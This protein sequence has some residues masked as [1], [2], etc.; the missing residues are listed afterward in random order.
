MTDSKMPAFTDFRLPDP[1]KLAQNLG[2]LA[3]RAA[4]LSRKLAERPDVQQ[5]EAEVQILPMEQV[6]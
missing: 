4:L 1:V 2:V 6:Q 5:K 3:E